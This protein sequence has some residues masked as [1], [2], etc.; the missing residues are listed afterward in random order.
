MDEHHHPCLPLC[1]E[2]L[3]NWPGAEREH[4]WP[5]QID[6]LIFLV[7]L[8]KKKNERWQ[9]GLCLSL[10]QT[11]RLLAAGWWEGLCYANMHYAMTLPIAGVEVAEQ[12][13]PK[14]P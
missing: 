13:Q 3:C 11:R 2:V 1:D 9:S 6:D 8:F 14:A 12:N 7:L 4:D 10:S 5:E